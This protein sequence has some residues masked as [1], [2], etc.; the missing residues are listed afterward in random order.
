MLF[1]IKNDISTNN[2]FGSFDI[3]KPITFCYIIITKKYTFLKKIHNFFFLT[4]YMSITDTLKNFKMTYKSFHSTPSFN[5]C[6]VLQ[7]LCRHLLRIYT[8]VCT[9]S[10]QKI[11]RNPFSF[12]IVLAI[13]TIVLVL[14]LNTTF[15]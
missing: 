5:W 9:A 6:L 8:A 14:F 3:E 11:F 10:A 13:S 7:C 1:F 2:K 4:R 15:Y 12:I